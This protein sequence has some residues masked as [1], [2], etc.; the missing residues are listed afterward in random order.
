MRLDLAARFGAQFAHQ[1]VQHAER[2]EIVLLLRHRLLER[3][4]NALAGVLDRLH[5][6]GDQE[7]AERGAADDDGFPRLHQ[8]V[9]MAAHRHEAAKH[10]AERDDKSD[11]NGHVLPTDA[12]VRS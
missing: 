10:A 7:G 5:R 1:A 6:I 11:K 12:F 3:L 8:H 4:D 9:K 2:L